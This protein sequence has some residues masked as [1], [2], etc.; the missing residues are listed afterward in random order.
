MSGSRIFSGGEPL[1]LGAFAL[2][3]KVASPGFA[4]Y[5]LELQARPNNVNVKWLPQEPLG[6]GAILP[7]MMDIE[8]QANPLDVTAKGSV[9][10]EGNATLTSLSVDISL[11]F[12]RIALGLMPGILPPSPNRPCGIPI[13]QVL[14]TSIRDAN[15]VTETAD[16]AMHHHLIESGQ[17]LGQ[18]A[19]QL[20]QRSADVLTQSGFD[21]AAELVK[22]A[23]IASI[24]EA[25]ITW[26]PNFIFDYFRYQGRP[27]V[28]DL[29][30]EPRV[31]KTLSAG[32]VAFV[33]HRG[34]HDHIYLMSLDLKTMKAGPRFRQLTNGTGDDSSP[35]WSPDGRQI[36]FDSNSDGA[37]R[38]VYIVESDGS[39]TPHRLTHSNEAETSPCWS[40]DGRQIAFTSFSLDGSA[41]IKIANADGTGLPQLLN[42]DHSFDFVPAWSPDGL[43][44]AFAR[45]LVSGQIY[46]TKAD[47]TGSPRQ[48]TS[49]GGE[50]VFPAWSPDSKYIAFVSTRS[51][52][53]QIYIMTSD[54]G[55]QHPLTNLPGFTADPAWSPDGRFILFASSPD[56]NTNDQIFIMN[57]DGTKI[58][59][60]SDGTANDRNPKW[61]PQ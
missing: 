7:P 59:R 45:G 61:S 11:F 31:N 23:P 60:L 9:H 53:S 40:P 1:C 8:L 38:Q 36:A 48:L 10:V 27:A 43:S 35:T 44:I 15:I 52:S 55:N 29:A 3:S 30:Y 26:I 2:K 22:E 58:Q 57:S 17:E 13:E 37:Q 50:N 51:N 54:G 41:Q 18:V 34:G 20:S 47:G 12:L 32:I 14:F 49:P 5:S 46:I 28:I 21:C 16:L 4:G 24:V 42:Q 25:Y 39:G 56:R 19:S 33:S 6:E